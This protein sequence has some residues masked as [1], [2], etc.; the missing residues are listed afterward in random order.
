MTAIYAD[1]GKIDGSPYRISGEQLVV[2]LNTCKL[3]HT[4]L[5]GHV[6]DQLLCLCLSQCAVL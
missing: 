5:H 1:T 3:D 2:R 6:I 4:E